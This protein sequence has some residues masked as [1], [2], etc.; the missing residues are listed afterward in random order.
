MDKK[1]KEML[2]EVKFNAEM[3]KS[4]SIVKEEIGCGFVSLGYE[5]EEVDKHIKKILEI[6]DKYERSI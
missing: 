6:V 3:I 2:S 5:C 4:V 1:L